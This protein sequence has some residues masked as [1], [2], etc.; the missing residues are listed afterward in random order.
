MTVDEAQRQITDILVLE[1]DPNIEVDRID[2][3]EIDVT[4]L[5]ST[6]KEIVRRI[7]IRWSQRKVK[8]WT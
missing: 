4:R 2:V 1:E 8:R 7:R 3:E 5:Q 6:S